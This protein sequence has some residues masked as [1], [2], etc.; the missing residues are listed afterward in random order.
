VSLELADGL[1]ARGATRGDAALVYD[2]V[3]AAEE[4]YDG[5]AEVD[6][7]DVTSDLARVG[8][9]PATDLV[10]VF[11]GDEAIAWADIYRDRAEADV[12]PSHH[13]RGIGRALL[14]WTERRAL[15]TGEDHVHQTVTDHNGDARAL[16]LANGYEPASTSWILEIAFDGPP[17]VHHPPEGITIRAY[18]P[19]H[20]A[21]SVHRLVDD[22]FN[23]W[24]G[25]TSL[26]FEEW[27][28][29]V[30]DHDAFSPALSRLAF[31]GDQLVGAAL[32][33]EYANTDEGWVHQLATS[34][35]HRHRGIARAL[36]YETFRAFH[37]RGKARCGLS[38]D[39][40]TG[41]LSLYERVGMRVRRSYTTYAKRL[42]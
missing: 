19:S 17:L 32:A 10:L 5:V 28:V 3:V 37:A 7:S 30:I 13:G 8:F 6:V 9:D 16:F 21:R 38:T 33:F 12:R 15:D 2:L 29:F 24:E 23:E 27:A 42:A 22:A 31:D 34:T 11:D 41:A 35:G 18:D 40:R 4:H 20:D 39:S 36:L 26:P 25:R 1:R 14:R